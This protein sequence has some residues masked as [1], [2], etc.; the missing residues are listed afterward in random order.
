MSTETVTSQRW[1]NIRRKVFY[2]YPNGSAPLIGI[3][4]MIKEEETNDPEFSW[5]E[6]RLKEQVTN[7]LASYTLTPGS[8]SATNAGSWFVSTDGTTWKNSEGTAGTTATLAI[9]PIAHASAPAYGYGL[10][11][12]D[13]SLFRVGHVFKMFAPKSSGSADLRC[14]VTGFAARSGLTV[15]DGLTSPGT[16]AVTT[17]TDV[18]IFKIISID[19]ANTSSTTATIVPTVANAVN[20][21]AVVGSSFPHGVTDQSTEVYYLPINIG[22]YS[23][24]FRTPFS[25][26]GASL[27]TPVKFDDTGIYK[28]KAKQHSIDH[29]IEQELAFIFGVKTRNATNNL[30]AVVP[31]A[32]TGAGLPQYFT[33]GI[34]YFLKLWEAG[35]VYESTAATADND[36]NKRIITNSGGTLNEQDYDGYL[37]R[38]FRASNNVTNEKLV[39]CGSGFLKVVNQMYRSN[40]NFVYYPPSGDTYGM[41]I[42]AHKTAFGTVYYK[43]H[44]LFSRNATLRNNALFVDVHN[45]RYRPMSK[46]DTQLLKNRQPNDADY[47]K[48]EWF[49]ECGLELRMPES[50]MYLQNVQSYVP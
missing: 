23:Q 36:D 50:F 24:I 27:V 21:V 28:D 3:L 48:D 19:G 25:F 33:G 37:E 43:T 8:S 10:L 12:S 39:L 9:Y 49:T 38:L 47:R 20:E 35:S 15:T 45:L 1:T 46:R 14:L 26:T 13:A 17:T 11:V 41:E 31:N 42:V 22:N 18:I 44:P 2:N 5:W 29:M 6:K 34:L 16:V 4:S 30:N 40:S 32:T 7:S